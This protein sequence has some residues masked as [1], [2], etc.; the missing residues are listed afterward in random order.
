MGKPRFTIEEIKNKA[1]PIA[2]KYGVKKLSLFGSY[3]RGDADSESDLDFLFKKG[4]VLGLEYFGFVF[5]LEDE[6]GCHVDAVS[7][8][9]SD[10]KFL[11]EIKVDEVILYEE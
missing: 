11:A 2:K 3:A 8:G 10:K 1:I 6:F 4:K 5:D 7:E 9:I